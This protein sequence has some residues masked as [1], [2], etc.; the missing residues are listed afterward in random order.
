MAKK[1]L[2]VC[3]GWDGHEPR[4]GTARFAAFLRERD[5]EVEVSDT[6]DAFL[7]RDRLLGMDLIIPVWT[8]GEIQ[9]EQLKPLLEAVDAGT[10]LAGWHGCMCDAFRNATEYQFMTGGQWVAHPGSIIRYTVHITKPEDPI[11]AGLADFEMH[12]EQYYMHV[13]PGVEVLATT[14]FSGD[15]CPHIAG[16]VMPV[17][18]KKR[19]GEGRV[20]YSSL[21]H[22]NADFDVPESRAILERGMLWAAR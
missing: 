7:D 8:M 12:S 2:F 21:G 14:T 10:G 17:V 11:M 20:F 16:V 1:A 18:W 9:A 5:F 6:L 22:V 4:E 19:W 13:D 15:H 3:G